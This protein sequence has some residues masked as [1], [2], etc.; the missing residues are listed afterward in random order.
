[1]MVDSHIPKVVF[2]KVKDIDDFWLFLKWRTRDY[3]FRGHEK[4]EWNLQNS[5]ERFYD[6]RWKFL[7]KKHSWGEKDKSK[8]ERIMRNMGLGKLATLQEEYYALDSYKHHAQLENKSM[9]ATAA[10][11]QHYGGKTRLLDVTSSIFI[12][13]FFAFENCNT[14]KR[15]IWAF[16]ESMLYTT[17]GITDTLLP[18]GL[19]EEQRESMAEDLAAD[20]Y[21]LLNNHFL[22]NKMCLEYAEKCFSCSEN[23]Y[24]LKNHQGIIPIRVDG[25]NSRLTAQNGAFLF[26]KT[27]YP[28]ES[29]LIAALGCDNE[30]ILRDGE[31]VFDSVA[32]YN[33]SKIRGVPVV[34]L[35]F[36]E[37][38]YDA[39]QQILQQANISARSIYPDEIGLAKSIR[40]W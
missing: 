19:S 3:L 18:D 22:R 2:C 23:N 31:K 11:L 34:K 1:M 39:A 40:Y 25:N 20:N 15:A 4:A 10:I 13:L 14:E 27:L 33:K 36:P 17:C 5:L 6:D 38:F 35:I 29:N 30:N 26:P 28:F 21:E 16:S 12:A 32:E 7:L 37:D 24:G 8:A 9:I